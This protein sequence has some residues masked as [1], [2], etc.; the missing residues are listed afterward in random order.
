MNTNELTYN[1]I[2]AGDIIP[3]DWCSIDLESFTDTLFNYTIFSRINFTLT[4]DGQPNSLFHVDSLGTK[5]SVFAIG[6]PNLDGS[7]RPADLY[8]TYNSTTSIPAGLYIR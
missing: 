3:N 1:A 7:T 8:T 6:E 4:F 2:A 5:F